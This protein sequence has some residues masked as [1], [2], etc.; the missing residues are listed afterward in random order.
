MT[1]QPVMTVR[2]GLLWLLLLSF[3]LFSH[4][5]SK[6]IHFHWYTEENVNMHSFFVMQQVVVKR[7]QMGSIIVI[8]SVNRL[9][10]PKFKKTLKEKH[11][12]FLDIHFIFKFISLTQQLLPPFHTCTFSVSKLKLIKVP[13]FRPLQFLTC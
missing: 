11:I 4:V 6:K 10:K 8:R 12:F 1:H 2:G 5:Y 9:A 7:L 3:S 13:L